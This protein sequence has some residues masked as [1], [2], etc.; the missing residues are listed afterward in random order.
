M[1]LQVGHAPVVGGAA[2]GVDARV[3]GHADVDLLAPGLE[4]VAPGHQRGGHGPGHDEA[5]NVDELLGLGDGLKH[6]GF[7]LGRKVGDVDASLADLLFGGQPDVLGPLE[8]LPVLGDLDGF[9]NHLDQLLLAEVAQ[10][11]LLAPGQGLAGLL[12]PGL[13]QLPGIDPGLLAQGRK[14]RRAPDPGQLRPG[15]G[16]SPERVQEGAGAPGIHPQVFA[17]EHVEVLLAPDLL[18]AY[19][20]RGLHVPG[21]V[22]HQPG[23]S[24][25][26]DPV[27][28]VEVLARAG[29]CVHA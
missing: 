21:E 6:H 16:G 26:L 4:L 18:R 20:D 14:V 29:V 9:L 27:A 10:R 11:H 17:Q 25:P 3:H 8:V 28:R 2:V 22:L 1:V 5:G 19:A 23:R 12:E 15:R 13:E 24:R 7:P